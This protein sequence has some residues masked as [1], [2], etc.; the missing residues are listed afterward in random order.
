MKKKTAS[1]H[2]IDWFPILLAV[3]PCLWGLSIWLRDWPL[4]VITALI[5]VYLVQ[6]AWN[7]I[8]TRRTARKESKRWADH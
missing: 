4:A 7:L 8:R 3:V 6:D 5:S 2:S 1:K